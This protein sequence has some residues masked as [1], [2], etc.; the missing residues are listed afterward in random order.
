[1]SKCRHTSDSTIELS[2]VGILPGIEWC[3][4]R[5]LRER[6]VGRRAGRSKRHDGSDAGTKPA[7]WEREGRDPARAL[8]GPVWSAAKPARRKRSR[9]L[10]VVGLD[11][12]A[13]FPFAAHFPNGLWLELLIEHVV[14]D[15]EALMWAE[16]VVETHATLPSKMTMRL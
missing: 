10:S 12:P 8:L 7:G 11:E 13:E 1:M 2:F 16:R 3:V 4:T 14:V 5:D 6:L 9:R 15:A